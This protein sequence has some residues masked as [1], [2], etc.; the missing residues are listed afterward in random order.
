M[1]NNICK[2]WN[3]CIKSICEQEITFGCY[4]ILLNGIRPYSL[5]RH[6][7]RKIFL[8]Q[9]GKTVM[10][11]KSKKKYFQLLFSILKSFF[12]L[13]WLW[14]RGK[15]ASSVFFAFPR[16]D[17]INGI[18]VDKF[19]DPVIDACGLKDDY[20]IFDHG[21]A[22]RHPLPRCHAS[23]V[24]YVDFIHFLADIKAKLRYHHFVK[25][26]KENID[27]LVV[28]VSCVI[29][30][31]WD[32]KQLLQ[33][34][35]MKL[36]YIEILY[37][38]FKRMQT[39]RVLGPGLGF[40][41][42]PFIAIH[43]LGGKAYEFQ[44]GITYGETLTYSGYRDEMVI[45]DKFLAFGKN[46]PKS[47]YGVE[48]ERMVNV[49]WA[50]PNYLDKIVD[51]PHY[52][53]EDVLV[54]SDPEITDYVLDMIGLLAKEHP[55]CH[56]YFRPHPHEHLNKKQIDMIEGIDNLH[57]QDKSINISV[58]L[59][60]FSNVVGENSTVLYEALSLGKKVGK[61]FGNGLNPIYLTDK[62]KNCFW[63]IKDKVSFRTFIEADNSL[64]HVRSIYSKFDKD[65]MLNS[66]FSNDEEE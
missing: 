6:T 52:S 49:G 47:V 2:G 8:E 45:P 33:E 35:V 63:E 25:K 5:I 53:P 4:D 62:D 16:V 41:T 27:R 7:V 29:G 9:N 56:F 10:S 20:L 15:P 17:K 57:L 28:A 66:V 22:G 31:S 51:F 64:K 40:L 13:S 48:E 37:A 26:N 18:Y 12:Q 43:K 34:M 23:K 38:V 19:T 46:V 58:V 65:Y 61:L 42:Y 39:K 60:C 14:L 11:L 50:L 54:V 24:V 36:F 1:D 32:K 55:M 59:Q 30:E 44:H 21:R 3:G